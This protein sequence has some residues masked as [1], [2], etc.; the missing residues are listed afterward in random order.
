MD[1][2]QEQPSTPQFGVRPTQHVSQGGFGIT[3]TETQHTE[4]TQPETQ[5][6]AT[7]STSVDGTH[8][9]RSRAPDPDDNDQDIQPTLDRWDVAAL[10]INKIVGTG[11]FTGP[12][13]VLIYTQSKAEA[14]SLW[15]LGLVYTYL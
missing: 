7:E 13:L 10:I 3:A 5:A 4:L 1:S 6:T 8:G 9:I 15:I 2:T 12:P 11:I 14:M